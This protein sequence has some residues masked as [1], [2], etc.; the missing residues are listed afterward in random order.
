VGDFNTFGQC[1]A[2]D[3]VNILSQNVMLWRVLVGCLCYFRNTSK[4]QACTIYDFLM[5][6]MKSNIL[7]AHGASVW[8]LHE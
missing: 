8:C 7:K 3:N 4:G 6:H 5:S 1:S 2:N